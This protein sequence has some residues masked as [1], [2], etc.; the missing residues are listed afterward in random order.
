MIFDFSN[1]IFGA[2][3]ASGVLI[4]YEVSAIGG[5]AAPIINARMLTLLGV[6]E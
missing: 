2:A 4:L 6:G 3:A 1:S 5:G